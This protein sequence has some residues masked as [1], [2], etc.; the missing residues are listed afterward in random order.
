MEQE[1]EKKIREASKRLLVETKVSHMD[2]EARQTTGKRNRRAQRGKI[3]IIAVCV[4]V[5]CTLSVA[6][7]SGQLTFI[8]GRGFTFLGDDSVS[9][10][11]EG[12]ISFE[13]DGYTHHIL[14]A[15]IRR[16]RLYVELFYYNTTAGMTFQPQTKAPDYQVYCHGKAGGDYTKSY[17]T[18]ISLSYRLP[19]IDKKSDMVVSLYA[20]EALL[21]DIRLLPVYNS[22]KFQRALPHSTVNGVTLTANVHQ[23]D[24]NMVVY[25]SAILP[26]DSIRGSDNQIA[27]IDNHQLGFSEKNIYME[28]ENGVTYPDMKSKYPENDQL[29]LA[30]FWHFYSFEIPKNAESLK[31]II[32]E[33]SYLTGEGKEKSLT[34]PWEIALAY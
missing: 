25:I 2:Y 30:S 3:L 16:G 5:V 29:T 8:P 11:I 24:Q 4:L 23:N 21:G 20:D 17:G 22:E 31:I 27:M 28:D 33:I 9:H 13:K 18:S 14:S 6:A 15:Y 1:F 12:S 7:F 34:G 19:K 10:S 32:P 26:K